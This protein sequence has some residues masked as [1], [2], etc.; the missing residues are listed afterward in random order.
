M[1]KMKSRTFFTL[2][3]F[4]LTTCKLLA[5]VTGTISVQGD[6]DKFYPVSFLDGANG[7]NIATELEIG[8]S[9]VH[10]G[11]TWTGSIIAKFRYH[12]YNWGNGSDFIDAD[13]REENLNNTSLNRFIAGWRDVTSHNSTSTIIIWMRGN[14][15]YFYRS[16]FAVNPVVYDG[17]Q[18]PLPYQQPL[19]GP[20]FTYK[21]AIDPYVNPDGFSYNHTAYF[22]G[23]G[24]NSFTGNIGIGTTNTGSYKLAVE[25]TIGARKVKVTQAA[26]AD[27]VFDPG[28]KLMPLNEVEE[29]IKGNQH[30]P[31]IP[32]TAEVVKDGVDLGET[33]KQLLQKIEELTLYL[34]G[35]QKTINALQ[36]AN[37]AQEA[38]IQA[39]EKK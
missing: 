1:P 27:F 35:L 31:G 18:N 7:N 12:A 11:G 20:T 26:W 23:P 30:L 8:R 10:Y 9:S 21:T 28:Y 13:I 6:V 5:Q 29:Y 39:L 14:T 19:N 36:A 3:V 25:G 33:N 34:I 37:A 22:N 15:S 16:N 32:T 2:V 38:R 4:L 24:T 17:V